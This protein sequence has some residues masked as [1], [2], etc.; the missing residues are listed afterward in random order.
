MPE[1]P[2]VTTTV[3]GIN[4]VAKGLIIEDVWSD[5]PKLVR[6][7][8]FSDFKK[9]IKGRK[10]LNAERRAKNILI[11]LSEG[12][13][14][15]IHMKMT[16]HVMYGKYREAKKD[17]KPG[18]RWLPVDEDHK[19]PLNDPYNRFLHLIF[20]LS[21]GHQLVLA[22]TRKFAKVLLFDTDK[23][24]TH[25]DLYLLG[26]EPLDKSHTL[27]VFK[28]RL[29]KKAHWPIK[30]ALMNQE[31]IAGIG[32]IYSDEILWDS[33]IHPIQKFSEINEDKI[34]KMYTATQKILEKSIRLGGDSTSDYRNIHGERGGF[35]NVHMVYRRTGEPCRKKSCRGTTTRI[36]VAT[37]SAHFCSEHQKLR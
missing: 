17:D 37:R 28:E 21:N 9:D 3:S 36:I 34:K 29:D 27:K 26:P 13:T 5:W 7:G 20:F 19:H 10:I 6:S 14:L 1:L 4:K 2:E 16:G 33:G 30:Q 31:L 12:K 18:W 24:K 11:N 23:T 8:K 32:N 25:P 35:Q 15:L 22:D